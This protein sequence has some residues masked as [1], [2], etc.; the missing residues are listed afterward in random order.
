MINFFYTISFFQNTSKDYLY[1]NVDES[2]VSRNTIWTRSWSLRGRTPELQTINLTERVSLISWI[3]S[4]RW[5]FSQAQN[6]TVNADVFSN[7]LIDLAKFIASRRNERFRRRVIIL[8]NA[9]Y[10][11]TKEV[12]KILKKNFNW[13]IFLSPYTPSF[14]P[15]EH[16]FSVC[17][18]NILKQSKRKSLNLKSPQGQKLVREALL[19][20][21]QHQIAR[22]WNHCLVE[23]KTYAENFIHCHE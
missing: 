15:I 13:I 7:Y 18:R 17:K 14:A 5:S 8:G 19:D 3:S 11:K 20:V 2:S 22:M 1:I 10:H 6:R 4:N 9:S 12:M 16:Y 23:M 21:E